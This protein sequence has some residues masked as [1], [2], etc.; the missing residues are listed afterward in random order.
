MRKE[1]LQIINI[2]KDRKQDAFIDDNFFSPTF[3]FNEEHNNTEENKKPATNKDIEYLK[4]EEPS[5]SKNS[6]GSKLTDCCSA[7]LYKLRNINESL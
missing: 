2:F 3:T 6:S 7:S 1:C 5:S 4:S